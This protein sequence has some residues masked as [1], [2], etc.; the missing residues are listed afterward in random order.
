MGWAWVLPLGAFAARKPLAGAVRSR[1][2][3]LR[4][5]DRA[6]AAARRQESG[7]LLL[8][9]KMA[10]LD[11]LMQQHGAAFVESVSRVIA[12]RVRRQMRGEDLV[13]RT[14]D[15]EF[16]LL[17]QH[18]DGSLRVAG[19]TIAQRVTA[20]LTKPYGMDGERF[21]LGL[22]IGIASFPDDALDAAGL[23]LAASQALHAARRLDSD[24]WRFASTLTAP[25]NRTR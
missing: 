5:I 18:V 13:A 14:G 12:E 11:S 10:G 3:L 22:R 1:V 4:R 15:D 2:V 21:S 25:V 8:R 23:L 16:A 20:S 17:A 7:C 6:L 9:L 19:E 24:G